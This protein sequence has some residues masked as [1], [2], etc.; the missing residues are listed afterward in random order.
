MASNSS[1][2]PA[3]YL[4]LFSCR[5]AKRQTA[6]IFFLILH[7]ALTELGF[8]FCY[9]ST[10]LAFYARYFA[11]LFSTHESFCSFAY[12][13]LLLLRT[14]CTYGFMAKLPLDPILMAYYPVHYRRPSCFQNGATVG[15]F[16]FLLTYACV[17]MHVSLADPDPFHARPKGLVNLLP[18]LNFCD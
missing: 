14:S 4:C 3:A 18:T 5:H 16:L 9:F 13:R 12:L 6:S 17:M 15:T 8:L 11:S 10:F 2:R 1:R 7:A